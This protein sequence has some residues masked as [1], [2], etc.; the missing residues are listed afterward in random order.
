MEGVH[1]V[2][3]VEVA[4]YLGHKSRVSPDIL[5]EIAQDAQGAVVSLVN[6]KFR[7]EILDGLNARVGVRV[8][9]LPKDMPLLGVDSVDA[10]IFNRVLAAVIE[11]VEDNLTVGF[12]LEGDRTPAAEVITMTG[13][14]VGW[15][16][17]H[18]N[19]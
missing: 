19:K 2:N 11:T 6:D 5:V 8:A 7:W 18:N 17:R 3:Q 16:G 4:T 12:T 14:N 1:D 9:A 13:Y 15:P 10:G